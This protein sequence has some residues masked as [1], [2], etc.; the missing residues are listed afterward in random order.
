MTTETITI[1]RK[2]VESLIADIESKLEELEA[3]LNV[4]LSQR[5]S[6]IERGKVEGLSE[7][8]LYELLE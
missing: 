8:E 7:K 5:I 6:D 4:E 2:V 1:D 3:I